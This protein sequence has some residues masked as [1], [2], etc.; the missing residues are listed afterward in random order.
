MRGEESVTTCQRPSVEFSLD[1]LPGTSDRLPTP[2]PNLRGVIGPVV[3]PSLA[4]RTGLTPCMRIMPDHGA[5]S[6]QPRLI[7]ADVP[8]P[9]ARIIGDSMIALPI[10]TGTPEGAPMPHTGS[11]H[12]RHA[13]ADFILTHRGGPGIVWPRLKAHDRTTPTRLG[14]EI[15]V[16][17]VMSCIVLAFRYVSTISDVCTNKHALDVEPYS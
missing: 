3:T 11:A 2:P 6:W 14:G 5:S 8:E 12:R 15:P 16:S 7:R 13:S 1:H 4:S 17:A 9:S 10:I